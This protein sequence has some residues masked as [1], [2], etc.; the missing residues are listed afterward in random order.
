MPLG[1]LFKSQKEIDDDLKRRHKKE[2]RD[3]N[4]SVERIQVDLDRQAKEL[5]SQI[6]VAASK[7][8]TTLAK[9]LGE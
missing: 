4:R 8:D 3:A 6:K 7:N 1:D 9:T 2:M 5:E